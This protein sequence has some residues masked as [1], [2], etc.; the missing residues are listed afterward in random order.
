VASL[1][2]ANGVSIEDVAELLCITPGV[3]SRN[4]AFVERS[5]IIQGVMKAQGAIFARLEV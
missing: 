5:T 4:Y 1:L 3:A 2:L